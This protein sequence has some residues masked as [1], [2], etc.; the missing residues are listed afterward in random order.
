MI[1]CSTSSELC[2]LCQEG[3]GARDQAVRLAC[4]CT[5][6]F[7]RACIR[8][9]LSG[10]NPGCPVCHTAL[11]GEEA[12]PRDPSSPKE[13]P[14]QMIWHVRE[15][16]I[17]GYTDDLESPGIIQIKYIIPSGIQ[18]PSHPHPGLPYRGTVRT[19]YLPNTK[20]GNMVLMLLKRAF[21]A[22]LTFTI[23]TKAAPGEQHSVCWNGLSHKT[24]I[25]DDGKYGYRG[26]HTYLDRV[27][28]ELHV[29]GL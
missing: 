10:A 19:A 18:G 17:P 4:D 1:P 26:D 3:L 2:I 14:G 8:A 15:G 11:G 13:L 25:H 6:R 28:S 27:L 24:S 16:A 29:R 12:R 21:D 23:G 22:G 5:A 20:R 9:S 7:H